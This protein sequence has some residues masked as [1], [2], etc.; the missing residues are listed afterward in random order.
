MT[1]GQPSNNQR[2]R[3]FVKMCLAKA[4][5][6]REMVEPMLENISHMDLDDESIRM[7]TMFG[8][9][10]IIKGRVLEVDF[11]NSK[12]IIDPYDTPGVSVSS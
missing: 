4:F 9:E 1:I 11:E 6:N 10:R 12:V 3:G 5:T 2:E 7:E 8:E